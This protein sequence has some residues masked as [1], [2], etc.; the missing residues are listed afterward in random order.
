[1]PERQ[2]L[3]HLAQFSSYCFGNFRNGF[4][5]LIYIQ[6]R[7]CVFFSNP[8]TPL[9]RAMVIALSHELTICGQSVIATHHVCETG[10]DVRH[11]MSRMWHVWTKI[12]LDQLY[13][14]ANVQDDRCLAFYIILSS[15]YHLHGEQTL[16][17]C[18]KEIEDKRRR[19]LFKTHW[20]C[21]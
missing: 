10:G 6:N 4:P 19:Q 2:N 8:D 14:C 17:R 13:D 15:H 1:V 21:V 9:L 5:S 20:E 12:R 16:I 7:P 18:S 3:A 11:F